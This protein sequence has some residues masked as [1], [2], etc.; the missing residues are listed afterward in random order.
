MLDYTQSHHHTFQA[1]KSWVLGSVGKVCSELELEGWS[2]LMER[3]SR[4]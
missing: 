2:L 4:D 3:A 1:G